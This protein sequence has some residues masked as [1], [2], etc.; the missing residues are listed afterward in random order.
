MVRRQYLTYLEDVC[1]YVTVVICI[2]R[3]DTDTKNWFEWIFEMTW[4]DL[5]SLKLVTQI[6]NIGLSG[7]R[8]KKETT[9][10]GLLLH[11]D[12]TRT[13]SILPS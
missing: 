3:V 5:F 10:I 1:S 12:S 8:W 4:I 11:R 7:S 2:R 13:P 9:N 6:Q